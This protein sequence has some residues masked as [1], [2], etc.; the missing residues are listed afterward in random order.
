MRIDM[1]TYTKS[2][3]PRQRDYGG[4]AP[5]DKVEVGLAMLERCQARL[6]RYSIDVLK[7]I[8][9]GVLTVGA[10]K[11]ARMVEGNV[12]EARSFYAEEAE[13]L[14]PY[15]RKQ[16]LLEGR[17]KRLLTRIGKGN[18]SKGLRLTVLFVDSQDPDSP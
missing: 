4:R 2:G 12:R 9:D 3:K 16:L 1:E 14:R 8:G 15:A 10:R 13:L 5:V 7:R 18:L 6:D 11:A 17:S